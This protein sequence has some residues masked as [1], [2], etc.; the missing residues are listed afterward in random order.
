VTC[1]G[2]SDML[3]SNNNMINEAQVDLPCCGHSDMLTLMTECFSPMNGSMLAMKTLS[4]RA[5]VFVC[6][7]VREREREREEEREEEREG[8]GGGV[9]GEAESAR[10]VNI[11][12]HTRREIRVASKKR[13]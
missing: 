6:V 5:R 10:I 13:P 7:C 3:G 8:G 12:Q 2:H 9:G 1:C 11:T 4:A